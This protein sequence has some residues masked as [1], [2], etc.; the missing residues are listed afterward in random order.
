MLYCIGWGFEQVTKRAD[1]SELVWQKWR[2]RSTDDTFLDGAYFV[3]SGSNSSADAA[4][5]QGYGKFAAYMTESAG[6]L[7]CTTSSA[8]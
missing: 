4:T 5:L 3:Q 7:S 8:C 6:A 1:A 2:W